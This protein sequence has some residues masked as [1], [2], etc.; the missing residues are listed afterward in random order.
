MK[1][2][3]Y[4]AAT[5]PLL[6]SCTRFFDG[7]VHDIDIPP[8]EGILAAS[9]FLDSR[10][11]ALVAY[12]SNT[13]GIYDSVQSHAVL[14][15]ECKISLDG[16]PLH[17]WSTQDSNL[18]YTEPLSDRFG[19]PTGTLT[20]EVS[21]P[22]YTA[23]SGSDSFPAPPDMEVELQH[24]A[25]IVYS[26]PADELTLTLKDLP[27]VNQHYLIQI[28]LRLTDL[29]DPTVDTS[30]FWPIHPYTEFPDAEVLWRDTPNALLVSENNV[31]RDL[32]IPVATDINLPDDPYEYKIH[33]RALSDELY[34]FY[35]SYLAYLDA[36][37]NPF[38]QP[39]VLYSNMSNN[40]GF[41]GLSTSKVYWK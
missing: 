20:F 17:Y 35:K 21:H 11:S 4:I 26:T 24:E 39:V 33:V 7:V 10:D 28:S 31:D 27:G 19:A 9:M 8:H 3:L 32:V 2:I 18:F 37:N 25:A 30:Y 5:L 41:F 23:V 13:A 16:S 29:T 6:L 1:R 14:E 40:V 34:T 36:D 15:A 38:A 22:D 12:V